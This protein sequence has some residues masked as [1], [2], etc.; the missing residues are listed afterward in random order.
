MAP[1]RGF[2]IRVLRPDGGAHDLFGGS[3]RK[4]PQLQGVLKML[5]MLLS[6]EVDEYEKKKVL[7]EEFEIKMTEELEILPKL[8]QKPLRNLRAA[9]FPI[10]LRSITPP[11]TTKKLPIPK[12]IDSSHKA[13]QLVVI[14]AGSPGAEEPSK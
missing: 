13:Y 6:A 1:L 12:R 7:S 8:S 10:S 2:S 9:F 11:T 5:T 3:G 14:Q 4:R